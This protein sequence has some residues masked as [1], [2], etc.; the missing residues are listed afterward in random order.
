[1]LDALAT[2]GRVAFA[3]QGMKRLQIRADDDRER[4]GVP[5][6]ANHAPQQWRQEMLVGERQ[7]GCPVRGRHGLSAQGAGKTAQRAA[8]SFHRQSPRSKATASSSDD[9]G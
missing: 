8:P 2:N 9:K 1:Q 6:R 5:G 3:V 4:L 7:K